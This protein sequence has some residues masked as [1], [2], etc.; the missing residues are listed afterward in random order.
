MYGHTNIDVGVWDMMSTQ[1]RGS[2][3]SV[4]AAQQLDSLFGFT[5]NK[6][7]NVSM[8]GPLLDRAIDDWSIPLTKGE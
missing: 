6:I 4:T 5:K 8:T 7:S 1:L 3:M 2:Y